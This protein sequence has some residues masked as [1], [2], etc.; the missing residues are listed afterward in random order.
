MQHAIVELPNKQCRKPLRVNNLPVLDISGDK[1]N[2]SARYSVSAPTPL[3]KYSSFRLLLCR[4]DTF[5]RCAESDKHMGAC[6]G[7]EIDGDRHGVRVEVYR[8]GK[9]PSSTTVIN[10]WN[11]QPCPRISS[12]PFYE[13]RRYHLSRSWYHHLSLPTQSTRVPPECSRT[14]SLLNRY[15]IADTH[16]VN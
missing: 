9:G 6:Q 2:V 13:H 4:I 15:P 7:M 10:S 8:V 11:F 16:P 14:I 3:A 5:V 12:Q 1:H